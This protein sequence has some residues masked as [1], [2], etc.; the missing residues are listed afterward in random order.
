MNTPQDIRE[1]T[2]GFPDKEFRDACVRLAD[3]LWARMDD[4]STMWTFKGLSRLLGV[5]PNDPLLQRCVVLLT[6]RPQAKLLDMHFLYFDPDDEDADG[7][8][9]ADEEVSSAYKRGY[10]IDPTDGREVHD[11]EEALVPYFLISQEAKG[12]GTDR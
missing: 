12:H 4:T 8:V 11:F 9:I 10:L 7:E 3:A 5:E 6:S 2:N 1:V